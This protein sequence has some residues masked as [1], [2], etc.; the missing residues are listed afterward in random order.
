MGLLQKSSVENDCSAIIMHDQI[1]KQVKLHL[2]PQEIHL[3]GFAVCLWN[4]IPFARVFCQFHFT[5]F[6]DLYNHIDAAVVV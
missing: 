2:L 4:N 3:N 1:E 6:C 5:C